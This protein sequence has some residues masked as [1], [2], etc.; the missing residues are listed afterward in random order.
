MDRLVEVYDFIHSENEMPF[1]MRTVSEIIV[2][3]VAA[4]DTKRGSSNNCAVDRIPME[5]RHAVVSLLRR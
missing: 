2:S 3:K 5:G 1:L 4:E